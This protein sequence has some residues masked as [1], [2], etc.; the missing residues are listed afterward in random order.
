M[1]AGFNKNGGVRSAYIRVYTYRTACVTT[2]FP[3]SSETIENVLSDE[4]KS[5]LA[6]VIRLASVGSGE[7]RETSKMEGK[8]GRKRCHSNRT[9]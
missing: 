4:S 5:V 6:G 3:A 8:E 2:V 7:L 1:L 9:A